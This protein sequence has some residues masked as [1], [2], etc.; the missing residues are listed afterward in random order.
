MSDI[1]IRV[2][3]L[4]KLYPRIRSPL[5]A[6]EWVVQATSASARSATT[7]GRGAGVGDAAFQRKCLGKMGAVAKNERMLLYA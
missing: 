2:E 7:V 5:G 4:S 6:P 3:N 1:A